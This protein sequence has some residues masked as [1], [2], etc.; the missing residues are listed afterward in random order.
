MRRAR[1]CV[2][3]V[4]GAELWGRGRG[5]AG[6]G[7]LLLLLLLQEKEE[8]EDAWEGCWEEDAEE[9]GSCDAG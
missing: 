4:G 7:L 5:G 3:G 1:E 8:E 2:Q 6:G 9:G